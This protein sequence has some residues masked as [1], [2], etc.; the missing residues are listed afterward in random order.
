MHAALS[1]SFLSRRGGLLEA[2][3]QQVA[4]RKLEAQND[5]QDAAALLLK[6]QQVAHAVLGL[7]KAPVSPSH[8][9]DE[10]FVQF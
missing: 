4:A 6:E 1:Y 8:P 5:E 10:I 2:N 9:S 3:Q 7:F